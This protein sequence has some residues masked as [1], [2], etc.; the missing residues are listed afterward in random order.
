MEFETRALI[1]FCLSSGPVTRARSAGSIGAR[2]APSTPLQVAP[3]AQQAG[4]QS[5]SGSQ[6][7]VAAANNSQPPRSPSHVA[8][9]CND[10]INTNLGNNGS[11][12][13]SVTHRLNMF[14]V[15]LDFV[16]RWM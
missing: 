2:S 9:R 12:N 7:T 15:Q 4:Q 6:L 11:F 3:G 10:R 5:I 14:D 1:D 8:L 13:I 16:P